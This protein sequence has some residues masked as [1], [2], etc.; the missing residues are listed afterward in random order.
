MRP[1]TIPRDRMRTFLIA[2]FC[3]A[4][5]LT[6]AMSHA[7]GLTEGLERTLVDADVLEDDDAPIECLDLRHTP[8]VETVAV[9]V[10]AARAPLHSSDFGRALPEFSAPP[11]RPP[12]A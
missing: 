9:R 5:L 7:H 12:A 2:L 11:L 3:F 6:H 10:S 8:P 4:A 1:A